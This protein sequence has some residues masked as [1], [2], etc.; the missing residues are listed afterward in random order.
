[1]QSLAGQRLPDRCGVKFLRARIKI[2]AGIE[3]ACQFEIAGGA[4]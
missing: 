1:M 2:P 3:I 4:P